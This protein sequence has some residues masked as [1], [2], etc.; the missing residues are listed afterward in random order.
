MILIACPACARQY[1]VTHVVPRSTV[2]CACDR[3]FEVAWRSPLAIPHAKCGNCGG[4][5]RARE[6]G[7]G[8]AERCEYCGAALPAEGRGMLCPGCWARIEED[9]R[10]CRACGIE[11]RPQALPPI[12]AGRRCPRCA[13]ELRIHVLERDELIE[14]AGCTGVWVPEATFA[15]LEADARTRTSSGEP[16]G[17]VAATRMVEA[18]VRYIPCLACGELM[19]RKQFVRA[20]RASGVIVDQCKDH[21]LWLDPSE[22]E[23]VLAFVRQEA[24]RA[25][26]ALTLTERAVPANGSARGS[27]RSAS[28]PPQARLLEDALGALADLLLA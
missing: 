17:D 15:R 27:R 25:G 21:G 26:G 7:D 18:K 3:T 19:L 16:H 9:S 23:R 13:G 12:P 1:D 6:P 22:L 11:I 2:R 8:D 14:C 5:V 28:A 10:H 24:R 4:A 20:G